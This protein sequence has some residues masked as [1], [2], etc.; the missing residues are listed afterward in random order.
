MKCK[1]CGNED[2]TKIAVDGNDAFCFSCKTPFT[3]KGPAQEYDEGALDKIADKFFS[4]FQPEISKL[5][6]KIEEMDKRISTPAPA[7]K[8]DKDKWER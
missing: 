7:S 6:A 3:I 8:S 1:N 4:K 2:Q 5:Q